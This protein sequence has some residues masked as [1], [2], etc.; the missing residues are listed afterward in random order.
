MYWLHGLIA[1]IGCM[2]WLHGLV[3]WIGCMN[4]GTQFISCVALLVLLFWHETFYS[5]K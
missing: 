3:T 1:W 2:D 5:N 4:V